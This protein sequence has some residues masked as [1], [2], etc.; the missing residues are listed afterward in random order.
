[1]RCRGLNL[2]HLL[3]LHR[4]TLHLANCAFTFLHWELELCDPRPT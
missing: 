4:L 3:L 2:G 1:M